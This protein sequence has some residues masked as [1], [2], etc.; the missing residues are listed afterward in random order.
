[1]AIRS[2]LAAQIGIGVESTVGTAATPTRFYEFNDESIAQTIE[3]IE[4]EGLRTGNRV[5]RSDR[6]VSGQKAIEGSFSM[7]MTAGN[8]AI[9]FKHA[10]GAVATAGSFVHTCTMS[11]PFGLGLTLEVGRPGNDGTVRAFTYAGCKINTLDLSVSV[12]EL[13]SAEFGIIGTTAETIGS[14]TSA[15]YGTG[16]ELLHF[17]GAAIT[18]AGTAYPC[19][20]FSL[21]VNNGLTGDRYV[22]GSQI[23]QQPIASSMAEV[24]GSLVA[25]FVD[26]TA[27]NR[28]V[29]ATT[30]AIV[31]TFTDSASKSITVTV[32]VARFDGDT[33]TVG[34][35]DILDQTLNFKGLFNGTDSP[36]TIAVANGDSAP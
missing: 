22:L 19:K 33:P 36:V 23:A 34:G 31:A 30:A 9:L 2:G 18:V 27:Y 6:F 12:G 17:A 5:L 16:L 32:P 20:D 29:N 25:E 11:D 3:R 35:P 14:V 24:T 26:A 1:M 13:L 10:L 8:T 21:S 4:S 15:S 28:V 7:D